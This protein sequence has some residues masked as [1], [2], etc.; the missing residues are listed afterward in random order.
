MAPP[1]HFSIADF[2]VSTAWSLTEGLLL[3]P[4][5]SSLAWLV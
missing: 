4:Y 3:M 5:T 1:V 2:V